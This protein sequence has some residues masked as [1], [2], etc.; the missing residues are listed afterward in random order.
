MP[1]QRTLDQPAPSVLAAVIESAQRT[2]SFADL[3]PQDETQ[4]AGF[5]WMEE[6]TFT[7]NAAYVA[8]GSTKPESA[9]ALTENVA[10]LS[11]IATTLPVTTEQLED[12]PQL[13]AY[14]DNRG[15]TQIQLAEEDALL[16]FEQSANGFD[17]YV[18]TV[19]V[20]GKQLWRVRAGPQTQR[21]DAVRVRDQIKAK[22]G[23][24]GNVVTAP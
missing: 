9:F 17:G 3:I 21:A 11:K 13:R 12:V 5:I 6:T 18:D 22:L 7:N 16:N 1:S 8:E 14:I 4:Q 20:N 23:V 2:P 24:D 10:R 19:N 15:T